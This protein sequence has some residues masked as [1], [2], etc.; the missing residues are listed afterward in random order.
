MSA[1]RKG[2]KTRLVKNVLALSDASSMAELSDYELEHIFKW[3][4]FPD[5]ARVAQVCQRWKSIIYQVS[6]WKGCHEY[7]KETAEMELMAPSLV[8]RGITEVCLSGGEKTKKGNFNTPSL[9]F[10]DQ[11]LCHVT[12]I[13][14]ASVT[15]LDLYKV[16]R[17]VGF[18]VLQRLISM[19][20]PNLASLNLGKNFEVRSKTLIKIAE[21][22]RN[23]S[24][25]VISNLMN[26][27]GQ[28]RINLTRLSQLKRLVM[29]HGQHLTDSWFV[30]FIL[31]A[32]RKLVELS[33]RH[34][35]ISDIGVAQLAALKH[36]KALDLRGCHCVTPNCIDLLSMSNSGIS[37][38]RVSVCADMAMEKIGR[39]TLSISDLA[40]GCIYSCPASD[41]GID[42]LLNGRK[43]IRRLEILGRSVISVNGMINLVN[44]S[45]DLVWLWIN[46]ENKIDYAR[47]EAEAARNN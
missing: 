3:L 19:P 38:L 33:I 24:V 41:S 28:D 18:R 7:I 40:V 29:E 25:L 45:K 43:P 22:C 46:D 31:Y 10:L 30:G 44:Q 47:R 11:Q 1:P 4:S 5:K 35:G 14:A 13:M 9:L 26:I 21:N 32:P 2:P 36:L 34:I 27:D 23:L 16:V 17:P 12:K 6:M 8:K 15:S 20:M 42:G 37:E 39:S